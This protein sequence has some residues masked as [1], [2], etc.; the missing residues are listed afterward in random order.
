M[1]KEK[2]ISGLKLM[3]KGMEKQWKENDGL[4]VN[5]RARWVEFK[6]EVDNIVN[7]VFPREGELDEMHPV[8]EIAGEKVVHNARSGRYPYANDFNRYGCKAYGCGWYFELHMLAINDETR[9]PNYCPK[10]G[11]KFVEKTD[12]SKWECLRRRISAVEHLQHRGEISITPY[13]KAVAKVIAKVK[14]IIA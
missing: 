5:V 9:T 3:V 4:S 1:E 7:A 14:D 10:C 2:A 6:K 12:D 11:A 8:T 13:K